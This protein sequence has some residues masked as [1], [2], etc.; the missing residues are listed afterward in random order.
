[1][2]RVEPPQSRGSGQG[3]GRVCVCVCVC[4]CVTETELEQGQD[5]REAR[6]G[7]RD[8]R[9]LGG[10]GVSLTLRLPGQAPP[11]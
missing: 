3:R 5:R 2:G 8:L 1:M 9:G 7:D 4:V 6:R 10:E 11:P